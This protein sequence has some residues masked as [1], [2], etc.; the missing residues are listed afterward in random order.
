MNGLVYL[1]RVLLPALHSYFSVNGS[2]TIRT[3]YKKCSKYDLVF[4]LLKQHQNQINALFV[5]CPR[6]FKQ[7][8]KELFQQLCITLPIEI[9]FVVAWWLTLLHLTPISLLMFPVCLIYLSIK[10]KMP[11][12][13]NLK[14]RLKDEGVKW[15]RVH[16]S[17][18]QFCISKSFEKAFHH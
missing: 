18:S 2:R 17:N 14:R 16:M 6:P 13:K 10:A 3:F 8:F 1:C 12:K 11:K 9:Y 4:M 7:M 15:A 5:L